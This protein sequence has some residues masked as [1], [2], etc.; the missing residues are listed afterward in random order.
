MIDYYLMG[1][2]LLPA[3]LLGIYAQSR[4]SSTFR[5]F[6]SVKAQVGKPASQIARELLD[7]AG[8]NHIKVIGVS[9]N[10]TDYYNHKKQVVALSDSV[11]NS[12]SVAAIGIAAHEVGHALQY[13]QNYL[14]IKI[15]NDLIP[16]ANVTSR[17]LWPLVFLGIIFNFGASANTSLGLIILW[18][19]VVLFGA[20]ALLNIVTLPVEFNA[21]KRALVTLKATNNLT[22]TELAGAKKVLKAAALTYVAAMLV[23]VLNL[24]RFLLF[25]D[26][27]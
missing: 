25:S 20:A 1:I 23:A 6:S 4:V 7:L 22:T 8:L 27:R 16:L 10:L 19:G 26:R 14:P 11:Y 9:G 17:L 2:I 13:K 15:R 12:T 21:S 24:V 18:A 5:A 3:I